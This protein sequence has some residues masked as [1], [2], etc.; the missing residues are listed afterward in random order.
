MQ[1]IY[2]K[3][4]TIEKEHYQARHVPP[5]STERHPDLYRK[6]EAAMNQSAP[7]ALKPSSSYTIPTSSNIVVEKEVVVE[8]PTTIKP[9]FP[10]K[11]A[12]YSEPHHQQQQQQQQQPAVEY[13]SARNL[14]CI[15]IA[16]HIV[17]CPICSRF[18]RNYTPVYNVI[19]LILVI[20]LIVFIIRSNNRPVYPNI[21]SAPVAKPAVTTTSS[22][23]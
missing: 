20:V 2:G 7:V 12:Y 11:H 22:F 3:N 15:V 9:Y 19:I 18:Y 1:R 16:D 6:S 17:D 13:T 23:L 4:D 8:T 21:A 10:A 5:V 14:H